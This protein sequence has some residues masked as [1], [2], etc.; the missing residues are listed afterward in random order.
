M[1]ISFESEK[2]RNYLLE[3][4][5]VYTF[6]LQQRKIIGKDWMNIGR[7][8]ERLTDVYIMPAGFWGDKPYH[9]HGAFMELEKFLASYLENS[10]FSSV[11]EWIQ[12]IER[13]N[14]KTPVEGWMYQVTLPAA[15][16]P[17]WDSFDYGPH[18]NKACNLCERHLACQ[19]EVLV[20]IKKVLG[21]DHPYCVNFEL[22]EKVKASLEQRGFWEKVKANRGK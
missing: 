1:V 8:T 3:H 11:E 20:D 9:F 17:A 22:S 13:L 7:G 6:R 21:P 15:W 2:A 5:I 18:G 10:G 16:L 19:N 14:E 4:G 12:E